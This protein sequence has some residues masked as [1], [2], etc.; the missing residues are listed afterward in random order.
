MSHVRE[1][2]SLLAAAE[3]RLLIAIARRLPGWVHSDHL[4]VLGLGAM[5]IAGLGFAWIGT[6]HWSAPVVTIGLLVNWFGDSLDGTLARVRGQER[7]RYGFY[8]DH[9]LDLVGTAALFVG[10]ASSGQMQPAIALAALAAY[11][12][13]CAETYLATYASSIFRLSF[14][15][16]GPTELRL[17]IAGG[18]M[19]VARHPSVDVGGVRVHLLD[20]SGVCAATGLAV[21]FVLSAVRTARALYQAEPLPRAEPVLRLLDRDAAPDRVMAIEHDAAALG[22]PAGAR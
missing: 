2:R 7:P 20:V 17:L 21:V 9:I 4:T 8:V 19:Y 5:P 18:A 13:V 11:L 1:H 10:M 12:L 6:A 22:R 15:G 14:A 16:I 3:K